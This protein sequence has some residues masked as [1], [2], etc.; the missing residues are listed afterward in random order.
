ME[1]N[2]PSADDIIVTHRLSERP[3]RALDY[4]VENR[5]LEALAS[6]LAERPEN[7]LQ[8]LAETIVELGLGES[9]GISIEEIADI[10]QFRWV[11]LAGV[12]GKLRGSTIP[13]DASPCGL[14]VQRDQLLLIERPD[15]FFA[16]AQV[17]PL[18]HEGLLLPF[19]VDDRPVG[20]LWVNSLERLI[21]P[22]CLVA[23]QRPWL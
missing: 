5:A 23:A 6:E 3:G 1:E 9:A 17:Q 20:T 12:W 14:A 21:R 11:A 2:A 19:H 22:D 15:R 4:A 10:R 7:L 18:I 8:K 13:F 16:E